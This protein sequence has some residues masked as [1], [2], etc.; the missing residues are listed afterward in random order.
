[1]T[2]SH[3]R[4]TRARIK[5]GLKVAALL[6]ALFGSIAALALLGIGVLTAAVGADLGDTFDP[7]I[8]QA[9]ALQDR[10]REIRGADFTV[11]R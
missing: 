3:A 4:L 2:H 7:E 11:T 5:D 9:K 8:Q 1:M 10:W 6:A